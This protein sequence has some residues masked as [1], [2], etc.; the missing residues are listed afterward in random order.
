VAEQKIGLIEGTVSCDAF[1]FV[2]TTSSTTLIDIARVCDVNIS[3]VSRALSNDKRVH[4]ETKKRIQQ[5]AKRLGYRPNLAARM[6]RA[7]KSQFLWFIAPDLGNPVD[8][9]LVEQAALAAADRDY[10]LMVSLHLGQQKI[11]DRIITAMHSALASGAI[12][13]RRDIEDLSAM[14]ALVREDFPIVLVDVPIDSMSLPTVGTDQSKAADDLLQACLAEGAK[15]FLVL[16]N[17]THNPVDK[18]R[19]DAMLAAL[20]SRGLPFVTAT[21]FA[22]GA[23]ID[24]LP[25]PIC[26]VESHQ[27]S[28]QDFLWHNPLVSKGREI[29]VGCF[30]Q[31]IGSPSPAS[32]VIVAEQDCPE[33]A[34]RT[35]DK[36]IALIE[37]APA[38]NGKQEAEVPLLKIHSKI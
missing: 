25:S 13:N 7:K 19:H 12:I 11:F 31:W 29:L 18:R 4:P 27:I 32:K 36:L 38:V 24:A 14:H 22:A 21:Q 8:S 10:D 23:S 6:L 35:V 33:I 2:G 26:L 20:N 3:T 9:D 15:S 28:I 16:F 1:P 17:P 37:G 30:D 34:R 5:T